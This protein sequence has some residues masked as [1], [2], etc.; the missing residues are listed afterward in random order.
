MVGGKPQKGRITIFFKDRPPMKMNM[1]AR[2]GVIT[3]VAIPVFLVSD[4]SISGLME[5][6]VVYPMHTLGA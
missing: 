2:R 6:L 1:G 3:L 5:R 4:P